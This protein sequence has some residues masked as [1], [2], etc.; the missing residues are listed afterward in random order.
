MICPIYSAVYN[1]S[2][3]IPEFFISAALITVLA[4][5]NIL[6]VPRR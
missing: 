3:L 4:W 6:T 1:A 2:Y 5:R